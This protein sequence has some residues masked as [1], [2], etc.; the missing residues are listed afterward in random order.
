MEEDDILNNFLIMVVFNA[1]LKEIRTALRNLR[2]AAFLRAIF[3]HILRHHKYRS[4][5]LG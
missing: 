2:Y 3:R 4:R 5:Q 1:Y